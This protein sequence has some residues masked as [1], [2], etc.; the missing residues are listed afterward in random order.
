MAYEASSLGAASRRLR[1]GASERDLRCRRPAAVSCCCSVT[2]PTGSASSACFRRLRRGP[3]RRSPLVCCWCPPV[4]LQISRSAGRGLQ[5]HN[6]KGAARA[7][8]RQHA[9]ET[10]RRWT[11]GDAPGVPRLRRGWACRRKK[12]QE[13][14]ARRGR[15]PFA[16]AA[17]PRAARRARASW[18]AT[19]GAPEAQ[20]RLAPP[21][22]AHRERAPADVGAARHRLQM[23]VGTSGSE[24]SSK[25]H[26]QLQCI[27]NEQL[28]RRKSSEPRAHRGGSKRARLRDSRRAARRC[29][30]RRRARR[31]SPSR[32]H[33]QCSRRSF[34]MPVLFPARNMPELRA[35]RAQAPT[36][37]SPN[38]RAA[39][40]ALLQPKA[41]RA[42]PT[43]ARC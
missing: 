14:G 25:R 38:I 9:G 22:D 20:R 43:P 34:L 28:R 6:F 23:T 33:H 42:V 26:Q 35:R 12:Q 30:S 32:Q 29:C 40:R 4:A 19:R 27:S 41:R 1:S 36:R 13:R 39:R 15:V 2:E 11:T 5:P 31:P 8:R 18:E 21:F 17:E 16:A 10:S 37:R 7:T 3:W 24:R